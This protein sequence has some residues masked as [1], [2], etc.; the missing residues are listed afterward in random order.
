MEPA[1]GAEDSATGNLVAILNDDVNQLE[2]FLDFGE[3]AAVMHD[4]YEWLG[5]QRLVPFLRD[6]GKHF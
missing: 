2:R 1:I 4:N 6:I 3:G 5:E